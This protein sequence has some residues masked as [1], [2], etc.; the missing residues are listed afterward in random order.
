MASELI[1]NFV[2]ENSLLFDYS[3][4]LYKDS[5]AKDKKWKELAEII[6]KDGKCTVWH[7][8]DITLCINRPP[9]RLVFCLFCFTK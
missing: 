1:I 5:R 7:L 6:N 8:L 9:F 3:H 4:P 2:K